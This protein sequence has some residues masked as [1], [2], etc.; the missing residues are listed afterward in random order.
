MFVVLLALLPGALLSTLSRHFSA[1]C[2]TVLRRT[3]SE[4]L[5]LY[6]IFSPRGA[7]GS[8]T[9][10]KQHRHCYCVLNVYGASMNALPACTQIFAVIELKKHLAKA[11]IIPPECRTPLARADG[12]PLPE[13]VN[14]GELLNSG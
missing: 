10:V 7:K 3:S 14:L 9:F 4:N 12:V 1:L 2:L 5:C 13:H 8:A 6:L 11:R